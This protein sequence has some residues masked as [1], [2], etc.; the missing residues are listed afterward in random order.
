M[1]GELIF[2]QALH[3]VHGTRLLGLCDGTYIVSPDEFFRRQTLVSGT[4]YSVL[5]GLV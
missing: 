1:D 4:D 2:F 3:L 5:T